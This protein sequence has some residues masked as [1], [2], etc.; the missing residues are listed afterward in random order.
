[1]TA[2]SPVRTLI[3]DDEEPAREL[4][5]A[6]IREWPDF[7]IVGEAGDGGSA[8]AAIESLDPQVVFLD[9][10]MPDL[11]GIDVVAA[12]PAEEL[13][14]VVFVTA[15]DEFAVKAFEVSAFDYLLKPFEATR[16]GVTMNRVLTRLRSR[17]ASAPAVAELLRTLAPRGPAQLVVRADGRHL[18]LETEQI[19][20]IEAVGKQSRIH[21]MQPGANAAPLLVRE[22]LQQLEARLD[23]SQFIRVHRS[24]IVN[25]RQ[26]REIQSWFKGEYVILLRRGAR[27]VTGRTYRQVVQELIGR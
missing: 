10:K 18:F 7:E 1:M 24:A 6:F 22:A 16:L 17:N 12:L 19:E 25:R 8:I 2:P 13:P 5:R 27:V 20:W 14:L 9:V 21:L 3:V 26:I 4:L 23:R 15:F 11:S